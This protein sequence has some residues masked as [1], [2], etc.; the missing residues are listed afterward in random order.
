[1]LLQLLDGTLETLSPEDQLHR[2]EKHVTWSHMIPQIL[3][4][5]VAS[6]ISHCSSQSHWAEMVEI[7]RN[8]RIWCGSPGYL[9]P[10]HFASLRRL[11][12]RP[13]IGDIQMSV[14]WR[15]DGT[16]RDGLCSSKVTS[17]IWWPFSY[18]QLRYQPGTN[19]LESH[20]NWEAKSVR[21]WL[22]Q[23]DKVDWTSLYVPHR[24]LPLWAAALC[25]PRCLS[26]LQGQHALSGARKDLPQARP[27][28]GRPGS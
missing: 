22:S 25:S 17:D 18:L 8:S 3:R 4:N 11:V 12:L 6:D 10:G 13:N 14:P 2:Y 20:Q 5:Q 9:Q 26:Q 19:S 28:L 23:Y 7:C 1:M 16:K 24:D 27:D 15:K 21:D